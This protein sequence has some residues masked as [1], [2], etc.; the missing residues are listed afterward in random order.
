MRDCSRKAFI[1]CSHCNRVLCYEH[2][3]N[4]TCFHEER[5]DNLD[6]VLEFDMDRVVDDTI[7]S[8]CNPLEELDD[9]NIFEEDENI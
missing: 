1:Q 2:F 7:E 4:R 3:L 6:L 8:V 5:E 9:E